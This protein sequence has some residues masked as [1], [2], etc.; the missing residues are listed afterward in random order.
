MGTIKILWADDE[1]ELLKIPI[2]F[3]EEKGYHVMT[4]NNGLDAIEAVKKNTF[5]IIFL[6]ENMPGMTGLET[7]TKIKRINPTVPIVMITKSEEEDIMEEAIGS[8]IDGF[9]IKPVNP[10]QILHSIKKNVEEKHLITKKTNSAYQTE[11]GK[12]GIQINDNLN[13]D[14]WKKL[15]KKLVYWEIELSQSTDQA[16]ME[17]LQ[18]QKSDAN[19]SFA[20]FIKKNYFQWFDP[21]TQEKPLLSSNLL[22][23]KV[24]PLLNQ[25]RK[26]VFILLDNFR[27]DQWKT[28]EPYIS[29][30]Y[31]VVE[32][33]IYYSILPTATQYSRNAIFAGL[34][35]TEIEKLYPDLWLNDEEDGAKNQ[36]EEEML[37]KQL[38]RVG[39]N[40]RYHYDKILNVRAGQKIVE[41]IKDLLNYDFIVLVYNFIDMLSH[42]RTEVEMIKELAFD[43][44][45]Y[46]SLSLSW[47]L[48]SSL[49]QVFKE[50]ADKNVDIVISTDHGSIMVNNPIKVIGDKQTS[51]NLRYKNGKNLNYNYKEVFAVTDPS[52]A[53]LPLSHISTSY[54]FAQ[55]NDFFA[56]PNN[57]NYYAKFYKNTFQ[58]GGVS[59]EEMLIPVIHLKSKNA[60]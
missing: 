13:F 43:E 28:F 11:F 25:K 44:K 41:N 29:E 60:E 31:K 45:A 30:F 15:Y 46:R 51:T 7:L 38:S 34:M 55:N 53:H 23:N 42:A 33:D 22:R 52:K 21:K 48:N 35:P 8:K 6:D 59:L 26:T 17:V 32:E 18:M 50:L 2:M 47:F 5:D 58:H 57:Y 24:F 19:T 4:T 9:L 16:M 39:L 37:G 1:I 3:L 36:Y 49:I 14:D 10:K 56:Y 27:F 54:I 20:K 12:L 40:V